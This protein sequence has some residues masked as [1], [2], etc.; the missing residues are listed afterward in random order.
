[1]LSNVEHK[2]VIEVAIDAAAGRGL[3]IAGTGSNSTREAVAMTQAAEK[4]GADA[5]LLVC[6]YYNKPSQEGLFQH[7]KA[8]ATSTG[9]PLMLYS[10]PGRSVIEINVETQAR[11]HSECPNIIAMKEAG[12]QTERVTEILDKLPD[13]YQVLSGDDALTLPFMQCGAVGVVSVASNLIP[14]KLA[15]LVAAMLSGN[16]DK[17]NQLNTECTSL[18]SGLLSLD[19]NPVPIKEA[20]ALTGAMT[21]E[22]RL[23]MTG[24]PGEKRK[25]LGNMLT[26]LGLI[27]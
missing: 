27:G 8:I 22:L 25:Q 3:V 7:Y 10:I 6:P 14:S 4:E 1:T 5:A 15:S 26:E 16:T 12:G 18:F 23:P 24:L 9:L 2:R 19:T 11:L 21:S 17:A 13:S 20:L